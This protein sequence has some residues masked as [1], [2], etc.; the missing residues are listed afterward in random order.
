MAQHN[1][2]TTNKSFKHAL[3]ETLNDSTAST[4]AGGELTQSTEVTIEAILT[5]LEESH[6]K[7]TIGTSGYI[8]V[9]KLESGS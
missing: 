4:I 5:E 1:L 8:K 3:L 2:N 9:K 7:S 6:S